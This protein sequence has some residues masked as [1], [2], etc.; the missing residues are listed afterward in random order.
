MGEAKRRKTLDPNYGKIPNKVSLKDLSDALESMVGKG[1]FEMK[2]KNMD[3][4]PYQE[5]QH[6]QNDYLVKIIDNLADNEIALITNNVA[7]AITKEEAST[8]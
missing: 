8:I 4:V 7:R 5:L 2:G 1:I 6:T 3:F